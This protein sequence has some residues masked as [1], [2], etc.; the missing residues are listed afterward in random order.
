MRKAN[1]LL[2]RG[3]CPRTPSKGP[4][5]FAILGFQKR[6]FCK[7]KAEMRGDREEDLKRPRETHS[8]TSLR[9][10]AVRFKDSSENSQIGSTC[11][12]K[13]RV[14]GLAP[15]AKLEAAPRLSFFLSLLFLFLAGCTMYPRYERPSIGEPEAWRTLLSTENGVEV[16]WWKQFG[17]PVLDGLIDQAL[18]SNQDLKVAIATVEQYQA[19]LM[20]ARSQL[21]PQLSAGTL[22]SRQKISSSVTAL[23]PGTQ[24]IYNLFGGLFNASYLVDLWGLVRSGVDAAYHQWLSAEEARRTVVLG[25]VSAVASAYFQ[26][27]QYDGLIAISKETLGSRR[28][29]LDLAKIRFDLGL[30]SEMEVEQA[31]TEVQDA[32]SQLENFEVAAAIAE[33]LICFLIGSPS[34]TVER[35]LTL[36]E[37]HMPGSIPAT[38][39]SELLSQR[40][41][42]R[43][44]EEKL[45]AANANIGV[46]RAQFFPQ[47][48]MSA[49]L[50]TETTRMNQFFANAS[51]IWAFGSTIVQQIFTGFA[52]TG[53]LDIA[54]AQKK[55]MLHS[56]FSTILNAFKEVNDAMTSHQI[57]LEQVETERV[58]VVALKQY[59]NLA[60]LRYKEGETDYL[61]YLDA[62]R[63]LFRGLISYEMAKAN[64]FL[65]YVQIYQALGGG[66]VV[67][68]DDQVM[69]VE[70]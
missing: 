54:I 60:D 69:G 18:A 26:L 2:P 65:S 44:A 43:A 52:L 25:L 19:Q 67:A 35:G 64:S 49:S 57:Y 50:G 32:E 29:S 33:N 12:Y 46:A 28:V 61:T 40:P 48:N 13:T 20:V 66:W 70:R 16:N 51:K 30:T 47:V 7:G 63:Q 8:G 41:D 17:D 31:I 37:A 6:E 34:K 24:Q 5:S 9:V 4:R 38:L 15:F 21:Y 22:S 11:F 1:G 3:R 53:N 42:I 55:E 68:A 39:P 62:E 56:Y 27:R 23:P 45:I 59:L 36:Q 14:Q 58:R 10:S